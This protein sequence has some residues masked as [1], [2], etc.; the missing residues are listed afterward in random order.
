MVEKILSSVR[1][2]ADVLYISCYAVTLHS[3]AR[4][5]FI[6]TGNLDY[7]DAVVGSFREYRR[8]GLPGQAYFHDYPLELNRGEIAVIRE[9]IYIYH[10]Q[11]GWKIGVDSP[12]CSPDEFK[13]LANEIV[14]VAYP[15]Y[16]VSTRLEALNHEYDV[17]TGA[18]TRIRFFQDIK[19]LADTAKRLQLPLWIIYIDLNNIKLVNEHFGYVLGDRVLRSIAFEIKNI[20]SGYGNVYRVGG[21]EFTGV[22]VGLTDKKVMEL[23]R[24]IESI[25]E[26]LP[27]GIF[28]NATVITRQYNPDSDNPEQILCMGDLLVQ[29]KKRILK[30]SLSQLSCTY[31]S[32]K[33]DITE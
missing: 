30:N 2:Q 27:C 22:V 21:D 29:D 33:I 19:S 24:Q 14:K 9:T 32:K 4:G 26:Q 5:G 12:E 31:C 15:V 20:L 1:F 17:L 11:A 10:S 25:T 23:V 13:S 3:Q 6:S 8:G 7:L 18:L 28:I 16:H